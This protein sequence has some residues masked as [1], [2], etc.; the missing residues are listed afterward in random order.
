MAPFRVGRDYNR[1]EIKIP[2]FPLG[3]SLRFQEDCSSPP[4]STNPL[5]CFNIT[6]YT[7]KN[8]NDFDGYG[9]ACA[10]DVKNPKQYY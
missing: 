6:D 10:R 5:S 3:T 4:P 1:N 9:V 2:I 7:L 8:Y